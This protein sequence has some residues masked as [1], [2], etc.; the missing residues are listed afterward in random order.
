VER[1]P[2][3]VYITDP[4]SGTFILAGSAVPL[5]GLGIDL[6]DGNLDGSSLQWDSNRDGPLGSGPSLVLPSLSKGLHV[7]TLTGTD[8][9]GNKQTPASR[10]S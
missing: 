2:P 4:I 6:E 1:K 8:S 5:N 3:Q 7:I 10:S 9:D